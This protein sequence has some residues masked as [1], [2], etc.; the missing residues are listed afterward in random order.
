MGE[1]VVCDFW[2]LLFVVWLFLG[3]FLYIY[4]WLSTGLSHTTQALLEQK[5]VRSANNVL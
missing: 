5:S 4:F 3:F 1:F 2:G